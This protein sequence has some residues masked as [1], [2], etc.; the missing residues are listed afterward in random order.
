MKL[1]LC[2]NFKYLAPKFL[3][4]FFDMSKRHNCLFVGY[5]DEEKDFY[6]MSNVEF[7]N[8]LNFNVFCLDENYSFSD[9]IDLIYVKGGN[10]TQLL[11]YLRK[12]NQFDKIKKLVENG[13]VFA[14]QSA[15]AIVAGSD[16]EWTLESEPYEFDLKAVFGKDALLGF[17][18]IDKLIFVHASRHRFPFGPEI[19]NAGRNDFRV[20]NEFFFKAYLSERKQNK[21]KQFIVLKD[22]EAFLQNDNEGKIVR[23]DWSKFP[24]L[25]NYRLF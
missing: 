7:L 17:G 1:F 20:S 10:T 12:Y 22:N 23:F 8:G 6:S 19:E 4:R 16:T 5:A 14:G 15:G 13:A 9:K 11:H 24:V 18:F 3:P 2:S 25:E 21:D